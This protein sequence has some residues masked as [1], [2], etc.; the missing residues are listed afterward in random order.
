MRN[1]GAIRL[2]E[3]RQGAPFEPLPES[4]SNYNYMLGAAKGVAGTLG[5]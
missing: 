4:N 3:M 2:E 1:E 5:S